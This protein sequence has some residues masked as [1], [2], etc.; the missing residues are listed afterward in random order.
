MTVERDGLDV[1]RQLCHMEV[2]GQSADPWHFAVDPAAEGDAST[3]RVTI[4]ANLLVEELRESSVE[5]TQQTLRRSF[6]RISRS[7][8]S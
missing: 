6:R 8:R 3:L 5:V 2:D 1:I 7:R 4:S